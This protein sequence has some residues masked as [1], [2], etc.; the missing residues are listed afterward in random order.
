[1]KTFKTLIFL[2]FSILSLNSFLYAAFEEIGAGARPLAM[3]SAFTGISNDPHAIYYNPAGLVQIRQSQMTAGY[4]RLYLGLEDK[5]NLGSGFVGAAQSLKGG[6]WGTLAAGWLY[7]SLQDAYREDVISLSYGKEIFITGLF[8]GATGKMLRRNFG[9]DIYT[10][11]DPL[12]TKHGQNTSN[13]SSDLGMLYRPSPRYSLGLLIKDMNQPNIGLGEEE[14]VPLEIRGGFGYHQRQFLFAGDISYKKKD[15]NV[16]FGIEKWLFKIFG[17]RAGFTAGSRNKRE[18]A[19]GMG[20]KSGF[21]TLDYAFVFPLAG[22]ESVAGSHRFA[23]GLKFG[24]APEK[25]VIWEFEDDTKALERVLE[26]KAAQIQAMEKELERLKE[27]NRGGKI[28]ASWTREQIQKIE[29]KLQVQGT[30]DLQNMRERLLESKIETQKMSQRILE[31]EEKIKR[32]TTPR[33]PPAPSSRHTTPVYPAPSSSIPRTYTVEEGDT[34]QSI[35]QKFY[36][37]DSKWIEIYELNQDRIERGGN[38]RSGQ[39]LL[40][41]QK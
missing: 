14:K 16:S 39:I 2:S 36:K 20:Y 1:M 12:F 32:I 7:L 21:L 41:P 33:L 17:L 6:K 10:E 4:G 37:N 24:K 25:E 22:I 11:I 19:T 15:T 26:E 35:A 31:L 29:E 5:S 40:L 3:G 34:L 27:Q 8:L 9:S 30:K 23:M 28:E 18:I 13:L 38:I